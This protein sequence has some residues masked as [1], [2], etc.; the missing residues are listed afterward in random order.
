ML[1]SLQ[2]KLG[3]DRKTPVEMIGSLVNRVPRKP[4]RLLALISTVALAICTVA[5]LRDLARCR[6]QGRYRLRVS[7]SGQLN[8]HCS[9]DKTAIET[10]RGKRSSIGR[11]YAASSDNM[12]TL[13]CLYHAARGSDFSTLLP[14]PTHLQ[15]LWELKPCDGTRKMMEARSDYPHVPVALKSR[16]KKLSK[17]RILPLGPRRGANNGGLE[18]VGAACASPPLFC[19]RI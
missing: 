11:G 1:A 19:A 3:I 8:R 15:P 7:R 9:V 14:L 17:P 16:R 4:Q 6:G 12:N 2:P 10:L 18:N 5:L 13:C